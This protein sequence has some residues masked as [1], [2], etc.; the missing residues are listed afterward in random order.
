MHTPLKI[1]FTSLILFLLLNLSFSTRPKDIPDEVERI[2]KAM[3]IDSYALS[4]GQLSY[5]NNTKKR[6][7]RRQKEKNRRSWYNIK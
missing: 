7:R 5:R 6:F 1:I 3:F 2:K 4:L